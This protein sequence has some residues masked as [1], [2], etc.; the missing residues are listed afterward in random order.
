MWSLLG[1]AVAL[2]VNLLI[3]SF[4][5]HRIGLG[6]YGI[7]ATLTTILAYGGLLDLG[8]GTPM[9]KYIAEYMA[10]GQ[11]DAINALLNSVMVFYFMVGCL[12][13]ASL[14][15]ASPWILVHLFH[16]GTGAT[17]IRE[18]Y[19]AVIIGFA[20]Y[21]T[22]SVFGSLLSGLQRSDVQ[23]RLGLLYQGASALFTVVAIYAG[24]GVRGLTLSWLLTNILIVTS[25]W[26]VAKR[27]FPRLAINPLR[28]RRATLKKVLRFSMKVQVTTLTLFLN[29]QVDRTLIAYAL[30]QSRL[31]SYAL[32]SRAAAALRNVSFAVMSGVLP[33]A[34]DLAALNDRARLQQLYLR[35]SRY[36]AIIDFGLCLGVAA[37]ARPLVEAWLGPGYSLS[38]TTLTIVLVGYAIWLPNQATTEILYSIER[39]DV[40]MKADVAFLVMH[41]PLSAFLIW[42]F[43]YLGTVIGTSLALSVTRL[44]LYAAGAR[45]LDV[46]VLDLI[47][48]SFLQPAIAV[49]IA[50]TPAIVLQVLG[51]PLSLPL[52]LLEGLAFCFLYCSYVGVWALDAYDRDIAW[53]FMPRRA[54]TMAHHLRHAAVRL[55]GHRN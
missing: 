44:Y 6:A 32:A 42:R 3:S 51:A 4:V 12:F 24:L 18:L 48:F 55:P 30:G 38:A 11:E 31:G 22:F 16:V 49:A 37:L 9:R 19:F 53:S 50:V 2:P 8:V 40:P 39:P 41:I 25:Q 46:P 45:T 15:L 1:Y 26:V 5:V 34:S 54:S 14:T 29:D 20:L 35:G 13:V 28:F 17:S 36:L 52:L 27:L 23:A 10:L 21:F 47:R 7:W 33:A 43:G